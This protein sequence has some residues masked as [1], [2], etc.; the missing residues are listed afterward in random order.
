MA[1]IGTQAQ[2]PAALMATRAL[3]WDVCRMYVGR[4]LGP[5]HTCSETSRNVPLCGSLVP[6]GRLYITCMSTEPQHIAERRRTATVQYHS[7]SCTGNLSLCWRALTE[8]EVEGDYLGG[9]GDLADES[10]CSRST[11]SRFFAGDNL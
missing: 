5:C 6:A 2:T 9:H 7:V 8:R 3:K 1:A 4:R 11:V 10:K